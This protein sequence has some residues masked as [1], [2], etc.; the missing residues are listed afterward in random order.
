MTGPHRISHFS[1]MLEDSWHHLNLALSSCIFMVCNQTSCAGLDWHELGTSG[2]EATHGV[3]LIRHH[4]WE[5][6][7]RIVHVRVFFISKRFWS[8]GSSHPCWHLQR[9]SLSRILVFYDTWL[10]SKVNRA[11]LLIFIFTYFC[12]H[13]CFFSSHSRWGLIHLINIHTRAAC[14]Q[15]WLFLAMRCQQI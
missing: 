10:L 13:S 15:T 12:I 6:R 1:S 11:L 9:S 4:A 7:L 8:S 5:L 3:T 14:F 2:W